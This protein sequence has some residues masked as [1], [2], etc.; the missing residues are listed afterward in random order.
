VIE[1][2]SDLFDHVAISRV[3]A[4]LGKNQGRTEVFFDSPEYLTYRDIKKLAELMGVEILIV[5][6]LIEKQM[7]HVQ[8]QKE[9]KSK[10]QSN[11]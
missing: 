2:L 1:K 11:N 8:D 6:Y 7:A 10:F 3:A 4:D 5:I 9:D